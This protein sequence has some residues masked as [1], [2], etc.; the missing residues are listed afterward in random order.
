MSES[1]GRGD[2]YR[3][4]SRGAERLDIVSV[5]LSGCRWRG[6]FI[7]WRGM[8]SDKWIDERR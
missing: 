8:R 4:G 7:D 3:F 6:A 2:S 5:S 1:E